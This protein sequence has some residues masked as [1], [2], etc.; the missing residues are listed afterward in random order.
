MLTNTPESEKQPHQ[1]KRVLTRNG[2]SG[3]SEDVSAKRRSVETK[4][5][6]LAETDCSDEDMTKLLTTRWHVSD[7][8][9]LI[10]RS[11]ESGTAVARLGRDNMPLELSRV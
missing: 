3:S 1:R 11:K 8:G 6:S 10:P 9:S 5:D 2:A 7:D 4:D